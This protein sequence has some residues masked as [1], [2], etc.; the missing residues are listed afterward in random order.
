MK[1]VFVLILMAVMIAVPFAFAE[2]NE[3]IEAEPMEYVHS[4]LDVDLILASHKGVSVNRIYYDYEGN[5]MFSAFLYAGLDP[6]GRM[7]IVSED[8]EGNIEILSEY[9]CAGFDTWSMKM[10]VMGFV[11]D[12]YQQ[13]IAQMKRNFFADV[14]LNERFFQDEM[15]EDTRVITTK[16]HYHGDF[17]GGCDTVEYVLNAETNELAFIYE[18][19]EDESGARTLN[20]KSTV[21]LGAEYAIPDALAALFDAEDMRTIFVHMPY[22]EVIEFTAPV[23][24]EMMLIYPEEYVLYEN[25]EKTRMYAGQETDENGFYPEETHLYLG[26]FG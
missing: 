16:T 18:Y 4:L 8:S 11:L 26:V 6:E 25:E 2:E 19:F 23:D 15:R 21:N 1:K 10:Y 3:P 13:N 24:V 22:D 20:S 5:E 17:E 7:T 14:R 9:G 12:E